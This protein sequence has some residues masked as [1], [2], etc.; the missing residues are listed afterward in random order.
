MDAEMNEKN[1][2]DTSLEKYLIK[3]IPLSLF[4]FRRQLSRQYYSLFCAVKSFLTQE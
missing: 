2:N 1:P 4:H 3:Q